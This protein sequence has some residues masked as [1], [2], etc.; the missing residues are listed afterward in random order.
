MNKILFIDKRSEYDVYQALNLARTFSFEIQTLIIDLTR[1]DYFKNILKSELKQLSNAN[2]IYKLPFV[3]IMKNLNLL[4]INKDVSQEDIF[5]ILEFL[6]LKNVK[7]IVLYQDLN[8]WIELMS[9]L[10]S[11]NINFLDFSSNDNFNLDLINLKKKNIE[12]IFLIYNF[13]IYDN[14][15]HKKY[16]EFKQ[17]Y[18]NFICEKRI[19]YSLK[20][21]DEAPFMIDHETFDNELIKFYQELIKNYIVYKNL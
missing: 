5:K 6:N 15:V 11:I 21:N 1:S 10:N 18:N 17:R 13:D 3:T 14:S 8:K 2:D 19:H 16:L 4:S 20:F 7:V 12:P 9:K